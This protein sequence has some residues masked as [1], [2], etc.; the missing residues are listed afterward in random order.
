MAISIRDGRWALSRILQE[1]DG[2]YSTSAMIQRLAQT[3]EAHYPPLTP[4]GY[5]LPWAIVRCSSVLVTTDPQTILLPDL[6][7]TE[8]LRALSST[9]RNALKDALE[10]RL[11]GY[12]F[13]DDGL[14]RSIAAFSAEGYT[15]DTTWADALRL[16][17][18]HLAHSESRPRTALREPH[19]TEYLDDFST[20]PAS[21]WTFES[22]SATHD[23]GNSEYDFNTSALTL[24]RYSANAPGSIEQESQVTAIEG[25]VRCPYAGVR[26]NTAGADDAYSIHSNADGNFILARWVAAGRTDLAV[27]TLSRSSGDWITWR[28]AAAG[29]AGSNV[30]LSAWRTNHGSTKPSDPGWY[31]TDASPDQTYTDTSTDRHDDTD[32]AQCGIGGRNG[33]G[34]YDTRHSFWK[35]RA[36][37]DR[38]GGGGT[39]RPKVFALLGV[40]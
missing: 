1:D 22:G 2:G 24:A 31:G 39:T 20:D 32:D 34:D 38:G 37:S 13:T 10:S 23:S 11:I 18:A 28:L 4:T 29:T 7:P 17:F 15:L 8:T 35:S 6:R 25:T 36:I 5:A 26:H 14:L 40:G 21:R 19:N 30:V 27:W 33:A 12:S 3:I 16:V 9:Q